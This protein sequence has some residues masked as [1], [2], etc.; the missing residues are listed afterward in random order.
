[1]YLN[2][3]LFK[4]EFMSIPIS[5]L[6]D[7]SPIRERLTLPV[8]LIV[9]CSPNF[10]ILS[11]NLSASS[12]GPPM[13]DSFWFCKNLEFLKVSTIK[14]IPLSSLN[15]LR[16]PMKINPFLFSAIGFLCLKIDLGQ[17][18]YAELMN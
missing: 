1:V 6:W 8:T 3:C 9:L 10:L 7:N 13:I 11:L 18:H 14:S 12:V 17:H 2:E 4:L 15:L 5:A 16:L